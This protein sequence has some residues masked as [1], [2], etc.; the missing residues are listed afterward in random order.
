[1]R[2][3]LVC[4]A[5]A[6]VSLLVFREATYDPTAWLIWGRQISHGT[7]ETLAGPSWKPLPVLFT[8]PFSL[9]G[10]TGAMKLW[11]VVARV[12]G[13]AS[14][15]LA[16][17]VAARL[18]GR[19]AGAVAA[20]ALILAAEYEFNWLRG[21][22]EGLLVAASL[23]SVDR[24]LAGRR[25][26]AFSWGVAAA[27]L[28]PDV[29]PLLALYGG[30]LAWDRRDRRT[31]ALVGGAGVAVALLWFVPE[32]IGSGD[33]LRSANRA[34]EP[35][36]GSPGASDSPFVETFRHSA[37]ALSYGVYAG[38]VLSLVAAWRD[39]RVAA[40][41]AASA[42]LMVIVALLA[43]HG[44]TGNLRYVALPMALLC[45]LAGVGWAW[46]GRH[47]PVALVAVA[48]LAALPGLVE[49]VDRLRDNLDR[50]RETDRFYAALP[51]FIERAG[52]RDAVLACGQVFTGAYSTQAVAYRL[53][54]RGAQVGLRVGG[55]GP[56]T[57]LDGAR[58]RLGTGNPEYTEK[59]RNTEWILRTTC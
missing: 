9:F 39:R 8:T 45:V 48:A 38:A 20:L 47:A 10:D 16:F 35:V 50:T 5:L 23:L 13:L 44:F 14:I 30:R 58:S 28:R 21:N 37:Q 55:S 34:R 32:Y 1:V 56:G 27:L 15:V 41:A 33:L 19:A 7:L 31:F 43:T 51:G 54:L 40:I 22:S 12:G 59:L 6:V 2:T 25:E 42:V 18:G 3:G 29:W 36:P 49:P 53:H 4:T 26:Q 57:V 17:R 11:L 24:H 46:L 52:G